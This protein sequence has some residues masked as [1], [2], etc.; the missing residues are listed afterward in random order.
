MHYQTETGDKKAGR[1]QAGHMGSDSLGELGK[2]YP[3]D[4]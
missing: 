2:Q 3:F 4:G 1:L